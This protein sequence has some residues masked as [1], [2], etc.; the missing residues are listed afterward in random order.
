MRPFHLSVDWVNR[1]IS[2]VLCNGGKTN[3]G[4]SHCKLGGPTIIGK[5]AGLLVLGLRAV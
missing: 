3:G 4:R 1:D 5:M 2:A